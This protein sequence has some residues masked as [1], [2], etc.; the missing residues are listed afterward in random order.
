MP[1]S[2]EYDEEKYVEIEK[3]LEEL[4]G[5]EEGK[6]LSISTATP[7]KA[8]SLRWLFYDYFQL[9]KASKVFKTILF[10]N[11]LVIG[12]TTPTL[13]NLTATTSHRSI[14]KELDLTIQ[15]LITSPSPRRAM[16]QLVGDKSYSLTTLSIILG[17]LG[18]VMGD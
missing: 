8:A 3:Y 9:T 4:E 10:E 7:E 17:E 14:T 16:A 11:L 18:R 6:V 2:R 13:K 1:Y 12:K 15:Q 5:L